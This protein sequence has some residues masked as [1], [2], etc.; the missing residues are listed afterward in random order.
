MSGV[1]SRQIHMKSTVL[2]EA[3]EFNMMKLFQYI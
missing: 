2:V 3:A 1:W